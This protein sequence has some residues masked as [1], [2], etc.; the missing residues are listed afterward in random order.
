MGVRLLV[1]YL[2]ACKDEMEAEEHVVTKTFSI[3]WELLERTCDNAFSD[4]IK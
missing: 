4:N 3:L 1:N 2:E